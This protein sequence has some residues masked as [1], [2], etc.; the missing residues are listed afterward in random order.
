MI[1][2]GLL[3]FV[4]VVEDRSCCLACLEENLICYADGRVTAG[5][6]ANKGDAASFW[7]TVFIR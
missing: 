2:A 1:R 3:R 6:E 7:L 5:N 4:R